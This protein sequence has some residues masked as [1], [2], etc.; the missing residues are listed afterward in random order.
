MGEKADKKER[1]RALYPIYEKWV[2]TQ[3]HP[4]EKSGKWSVSGPPQVKFK[5]KCYRIRGR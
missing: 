4:A 1:E 5:F 2:L 3:P